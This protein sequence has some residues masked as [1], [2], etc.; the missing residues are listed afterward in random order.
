MNCDSIT[1]AARLDG[2]WSAL[3]GA[4]PVFLASIVATLVVVPIA[5][6]VAHATGVVDQPDAV[7]KL[8]GR[9]VAYLGG[10]GVFVGAFVGIVVG[11]IMSG[12][13]LDALPPVPFSIVLGMVAI[14]FTGLADDIWKFDARLKV[15]GQLIAAA[16]LAIDEIGVNVANGLLVPILGSPQDTLF[17]LGSLTVQNAQLYY[18]VG[19]T[20]VALFVLGGC[21][22]ANLLD[23]LDG[24]LAGISAVMAVGL[25]GLSLL[26]IFALPPD[27]GDV[28]AIA[29]SMAGARV[30]L[31]ASMLGACLGFLAYNFN[32]ASIFLG[33]AGSLL[34][35]YLSVTIVMTFANLRPFSCPY[36]VHVAGEPAAS[37][38]RLAPAGGFEGF[39]TLLVMC[40]LAMFGLPIIDTSLSIIRRW[41]ARVPFSTPDTNHLHHRVKRA[42]GGS[43]RRAVLS[44]Y[45][46]ELG[47]VLI[48]GSSAAYIL[49]GGGRLLY[50]FIFLVLAFVVLLGLSMRG[51]GVAPT[52]KAAP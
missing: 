47:L 46:F 22:A 42:M 16:A 18:W 21:N 48:G 5:R 12:A 37:A 44:L 31:C 19:T 17:T 6:S 39:A 3:W 27:S 24:L 1:V 51:S 23:G 45:G 41:R 50:P 34:I 2:V 11:A 28:N 43:V 14:T 49:I 10:V 38:S 29:T 52:R 25:L 13:A 9:T 4:A 33:D 15:A 30:T 36:A 20:L 8:H 35:G 32:P 7:R 40:G 26:V